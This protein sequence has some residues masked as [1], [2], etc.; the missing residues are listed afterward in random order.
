MWVGTVQV[1]CTEPRCLAC[2]MEAHLCLWAKSFCLKPCIP[3]CW[4]RTPVLP[5]ITWHG[6]DTLK[7]TV[8]LFVLFSQRYPVRRTRALHWWPSRSPSKPVK[9]LKTPENH[10]HRGFCK[11]P[12]IP[13]QYILCSVQL[14]LL[15]VWWFDRW[16]VCMFDRHSVKGCIGHLTAG[17]F[18]AWLCLSSNRTKKKFRLCWLWIPS[19]GVDD[20]MSQ[21][22]TST[23]TQTRTHKHQM[24]ALNLWL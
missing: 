20:N 23:N 6:P 21:Q 24:W 10:L 17:Q 2:P 1:T 12:D 14:W 11:W 22:H 16:W 8:H 19:K 13:W 3:L 5:H 18:G 15:Y 4:E 9:F 7:N